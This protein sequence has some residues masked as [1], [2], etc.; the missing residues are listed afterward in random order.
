VTSIFLVDISSS[1]GQVE[2]KT[3]EVKR[4]SSDGSFFSVCSCSKKRP[5]AE[6]MSALICEKKRSACLDTAMQHFSDVTFLSDAN[7]VDC[8][9]G[10]SIFPIDICHVCHQRFD[11]HGS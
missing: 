2:K 1:P 5:G 11:S 3:L 4:T 7:D 10:D 9:T 6:M 8:D